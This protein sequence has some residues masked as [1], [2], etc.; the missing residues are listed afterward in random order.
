MV[1]NRKWLLRSGMLSLVAGAALV[2]GAACAAATTETTDRLDTIIERGELVCGV[3][4][5]TPGFGTL[6]RVGHDVDYCRAVAAAIFGSAVDTGDN[7]NLVYVNATGSDRFELLA[8][9]NIDVLIRT[10]TWT[11][12]RDSNLGA[13]FTATTFFDQFGMMVPPDIASRVSTPADLDGLTVCSRPGTSTLDA[14]QDFAAQANINFEVE[15][16][17]GDAT[18]V[19]LYAA[20]SCDILGSDQ[21]QLAGIRSEL[22]GELRN[23]VILAGAQLGGIQ[24][25]KEPLGPSVHSSAGVDLFDLVQWVNFGLI[26]AEEQGITRANVDSEAARGTALTPVAQRV[27]GVADNGF[28]FASKLANGQAFIRDAIRAVGNYGE[29]YERN[30]GSGSDI[31]LDRACTA[32]ALWNPPNDSGFADCDGNGAITFEENRGLIYAPRFSG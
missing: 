21:S 7:P 11:S 8:Q 26:T 4:S 9:G 28:A 23:S 27:L 2:V 1:R 19:S 10:T 6:E 30:L 20:G 29:V 5:G 17:E 16:P 32:Q 25:A 12:G 3:Q 22:T 18:V 31:G 14:I 15:S 24:L 13:Q